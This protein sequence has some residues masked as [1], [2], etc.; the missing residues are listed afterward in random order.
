M[1]PT[2]TYG[3]TLMHASIIYSAIKDEMLFVQRMDA[4]EKVNSYGIRIFLFN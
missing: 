3:C 1:A 4:I 2:N